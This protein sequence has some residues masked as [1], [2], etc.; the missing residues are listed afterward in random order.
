MQP[1]CSLWP[2]TRPSRVPPITVSLLT[3]GWMLVIVS[4]I[5]GN[6]LDYCSY[7]WTSFRITQ[8][9]EHFLGLGPHA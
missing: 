6:A 4:A 8:G 2:G 3:G 1:E 9:V 5:P 7:M